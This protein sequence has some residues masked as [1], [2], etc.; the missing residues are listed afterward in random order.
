[1]TVDPLVLTSIVDGLAD[2]GSSAVNAQSQYHTNMSNQQ[3]NNA[4]NTANLQIAENTNAMNQALN[5]ANIAFQ[6]REN[7]I[8]RER[9]DNAVRRRA[10]DL[11]SA[12]LSK[13]LAAGSAASSN[14]LQAP[15][16]TFAMQTGNAMKAHKST[17][18]QFDFH[19]NFTEN[20]YRAKSADLE[21]KRL[22]IED[23]KADIE[24]DSLDETIR[25]NKALETESARS[26]LATEEENKRYHNMQSFWKSAELNQND[27]FHFDAL[28]IQSAELE[29]K[30]KTFLTDKELK[31]H[32]MIWYDTQS[33]LNKVTSYATSAKLTSET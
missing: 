25:H 31:E 28:K 9:E 17:A 29:L 10:I 19:S 6:E 5:E 18:P 8:T 24:R 27:R 12:G 20:L 26:N 11:A 7:A 4:T 1:M 33:A 30:D 21:D 16:N 2:L 32:Q 22:D 3:M 23:K 13:T 15:Q 14:A